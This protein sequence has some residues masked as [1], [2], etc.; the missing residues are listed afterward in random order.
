M[1]N[2]GDNLI[3]ATNMCLHCEKENNNQPATK[4][5]SY[6]SQTKQRAT[7]ILLAALLHCAPP[8]NLLSSTFTQLWNN[9]Q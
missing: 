9:K 4:P 2:M 5:A 6:G 7:S 8:N 1:V 3:T